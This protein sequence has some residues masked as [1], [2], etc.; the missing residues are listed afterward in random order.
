MDG[1][2]ME[3]TKEIKAEDFLSLIYC[4]SGEALEYHGYAEDQLSELTF[5]MFTEYIEHLASRKE[6]IQLLS[7]K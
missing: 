7:S 4:L 2:E 1:I 5:D 3:V 6:V